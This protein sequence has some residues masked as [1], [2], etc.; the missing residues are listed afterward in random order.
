[1]WHN[2]S[3]D[4]HVIENYGIKPSGFY[5]DTMHMARLWDSSRRTDGGYSLEALTTDPNVMSENKMCQDED[6][7]GKTSMK[8]IFGKR[9]MKK[10]GSLGKTIVLPSVED[11]QREERQPWICYSSLDS[12]STLK[13]YKSLISKLS[14]MR[15]IIDG[16]HMGNMLDFY[17]NYWLP[18]GQL[19]VQM[20]TEGMLVDRAYLSEVEK[21]A[22]AQQRVAADHFRNWASKY[23]PDAKYMN[24]GSDAQLRQLLFGGICNRSLFWFFNNLQN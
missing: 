10:D 15:W 12:I 17:R 21:V 20:E 24:V 14:K 8:T 4:C 16:K 2:Y 22:I 9:K 3:F 23:C 6:L 18:F 1:M 7:M 19:L 5:A 13:L 11:L